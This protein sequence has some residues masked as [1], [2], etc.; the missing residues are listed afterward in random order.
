MS[1]ESVWANLEE[2]YNNS[3]CATKA[4]FVSQLF[5]G[6]TGSDAD[7]ILDRINSALKNSASPI[8]QEKVVSIFTAYQAGTID[9][10]KVNLDLLSVTKTTVHSGNLSNDMSFQFVPFDGQLDLLKL[11][12]VATFCATFDSNGKFDMHTKLLNPDENVFAFQNDIA[13]KATIS[14]RKRWKENVIYTRGID[15]GAISGFTVVEL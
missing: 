12:G 1:V 11:Y 6:M 9:F 5:N 7:Y 13:M 10:E 3:K 14:T 8:L 2:A 4:Q 15:V